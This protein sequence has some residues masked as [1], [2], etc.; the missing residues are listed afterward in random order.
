MVLQNLTGISVAA[1]FDLPAAVGLLGGTISL[2][3]GHGTAIAWAPNIAQHYGVADAMAIGIACATFGL[4]LASL[5]GGPIA[6]FL[7]IRNKLAP[8][9]VETQDVGLP[10]AQRKEGVGHLD[11]LDA[12]LAIHVSCPTG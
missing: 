3:G 4:I 2:I 6:R 1:L 5:M 12:V 11:F 8:E 10:D 7:I 9:R